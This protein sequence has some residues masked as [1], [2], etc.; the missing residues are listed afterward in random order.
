MDNIIQCGTKLKDLKAIL[1]VTAE[2][3]N[4]NISKSSILIKKIS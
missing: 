1:Y 3:S 4:A 2:Y